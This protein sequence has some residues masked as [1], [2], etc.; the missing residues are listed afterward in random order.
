MLKT[1]FQPKTETEINRLLSFSGIPTDK[2]GNYICPHCQSGTKSSRTS[3]F[4]VFQGKRAGRYFCHACGMGGDYYDLAKILNME[5]EISDPI[6]ENSHKTAQNEQKTPFSPLPLQAIRQANKRLKSQNKDAT[7]A[8]DYLD[9]RGLLNMALIDYFLIG[10]AYNRH[11]RP[12]IL[13]P[14]FGNEI[15]PKTNNYKVLGHMERYFLKQDIERGK[16]RK[17]PQQPFAIW[18][19]PTQIATNKP[20]LLFEGIID[21]LTAYQIPT[22]LKRFH[23]IAINGAGNVRKFIDYHKM[24]ENKVFTLMDNDMAGNTATDT[25]LQAWNSVDLREILNGYQ[26]LNQAY[27]NGVFK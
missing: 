1:H 15:D 19:D 21:A 8:L 26:D 25:L 23:P 10:I 9:S 12:F 22:L 27:L 6:Q 16:E 14:I 13:F 2:A 11:E 3:G 18:Q 17:P 5:I 4:K 7:N 20:L 24:N